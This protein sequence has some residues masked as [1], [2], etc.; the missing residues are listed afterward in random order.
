MISS[1]VRPSNSNCARFTRSTCPLGPT[2][3]NPSGASL[4]KSAKS[5]SLCRSASSACFCRVMSRAMLDMPMMPPLASRMGA[6]VT[7]TGTLR[8][9][10]ASRVVS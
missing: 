8:P 5:R 10:L 9:S 1:L 7:E 6:D 3:S 2:Q 4:K